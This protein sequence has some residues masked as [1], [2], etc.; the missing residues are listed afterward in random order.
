MTD[1]EP[2]IEPEEPAAGEPEAEDQEARPWRPGDG[3]PYPAAVMAGS[4]DGFHAI[5]STLPFS[6]DSFFLTK[7]GVRDVKFV[8]SKAVKSSAQPEPK[9]PAK[10]RNTEQVTLYLNGVEVEEGNREAEKYLRVEVDSGDVIY[11]WIVE[12]EKL[13]QSQRRLVLDVTPDEVRRIESL[14]GG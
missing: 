7:D 6:N 11:G 10:P 1:D 8:R 12:I 9:P 13:N 3:P 14:M 5:D 4:V 2:Q